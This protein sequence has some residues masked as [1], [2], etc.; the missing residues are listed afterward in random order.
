MDLL[1][2]IYLIYAPSWNDFYT[3]PQIWSSSTLDPAKVLTMPQPNF[4][5]IDNKAAPGISY[6]T[7]AQIP[8]AGTAANPQSDGS[9]PPKLFQQFKLK[10]AT[11]HNRIGVCSVL[12]LPIDWL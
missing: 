9:A 4:P 3:T 12:G 11:F 1:S 6:Y 10:D 5:D 2:L 7:P 8:P